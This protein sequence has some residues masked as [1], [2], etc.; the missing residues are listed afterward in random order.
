MRINLKHKLILFFAVVFSFLLFPPKA[1][2]AD[3]CPNPTDN[4]CWVTKSPMPT[5]RRELG[6]ASDSTGKIYAVG[7]YNGSF[8]NTLEMY[9]P[10]TDTWITKASLSTPRNA[11]G[12]TFLP[13][14]GKFYAVGGFNN[15]NHLDD[16]YEYDTTNDKW[17]KKNSMSKPRQGL[18]LVAVNGK[19][20]AIG[21]STSDGFCVDTVEEYNP[22][23]DLW[24][25]KTSMS[26]PRCRPGILVF[27]NKIYAIGGHLDYRNNGINLATVEEYDPATNIWT[28]KN[29]MSIARSVMGVSVNNNGRIYAVGGFIGQGSFQLTNIVEEY[30][31]DTDTWTTRTPLP[32]AIHELGLALGGDG[33]V[34][35]IGGQTMSNTAVN[36]NYAGF[37]PLS[38]PVPLLKQ[39]SEP[40]QAY[41]Y[42]SATLWNPSNPTINR[43]GCAMTSAAMI[44]RYHGIKKLPDGI[45]LDPDTLN[46]WLK[47][48]PDG[49]V[50]EGWVNWLALSRLSMLATSVNDITT[51][52]ALEYDRKGWAD[53]TQLT[54]DIAN[55]IPGIL[56]EFGHFI[57]GEGIDGDT[58]TIN[59]PYYDRY[60]LNEAY[61][62]TFLSLGRY[63]PSSTNLSYIMLVADADISLKIL[64]N[65]GNE[66]ATGFVQQP[67]NDPTDLTKHNSPLTMLYFQKPKTGQYQIIASSSNNKQYTLSAYLY[68]VNGDV[69]M[70][71]QPSIIKP[72]STNSFIV[73][74]DKNNNNNSNINKNVT[75]QITINDIRE[76]DQLGHMDRG[77][78]T[79]LI[80]L[81]NNSEK[82]YL[83]NKKKQAMQLLWTAEKLLDKSINKL[84]DNKAYEI[85][86]IDFVALKRLISS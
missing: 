71:D 75:F 69:K 53:K 59:D 21:G 50:R 72:E 54:N 34:Y 9:D 39:T 29:P 19:L 15:G 30:D 20:Y 82:M 57:V 23:S 17:T 60:T 25:M 36:T 79:A 45:T 8:L 27:E 67:I 14:N 5:A 64:D 62:N 55:G 47:N 68:D 38:L 22:S 46:T 7:G 49:Y 6:V 85:L 3:I 43:W 73:E 83:S 37:N 12:F 1:L 65:N 61:G 13:S 76:L 78:T 48:Q 77:I 40:W 52:D 44:F 33:R 86:M 74:F 35:A 41:E 58:F 84:A 31:P 80:Q 42:D 63:V 66:L 26:T 32:V 18:G 56:E 70:I 81:I 28:G 11:L 16:V 51:F 4:P 24:R 10:T 2:S